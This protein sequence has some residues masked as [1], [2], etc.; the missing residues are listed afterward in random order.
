MV[1]L[2]NNMDTSLLRTLKIP[3]LAL[4]DTILFDI[5]FVLVSNSFDTLVY[6]AARFT[7]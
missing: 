4:R 5:T 1:K 3:E 2:F 7:D 6:A